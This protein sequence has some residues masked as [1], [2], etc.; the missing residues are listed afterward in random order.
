[1]GLVFK[2]HVARWLNQLMPENRVRLLPYTL[3]SGLRIRACLH[4]RALLCQTNVSYV[5][6]SGIY[7]HQRDARDLRCK[8]EYS[9][10]GQRGGCIVV[11]GLLLTLL[12]HCSKLCCTLQIVLF[13]RTVYHCTTEDCT[14]VPPPDTCV[15]H[16]SEG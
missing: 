3:H 6:R 9:S 5:I 8:L 7:Y 15:P 2:Q 13:W 1:M 11:K 4:I 16:G 12:L 14:T 10:L